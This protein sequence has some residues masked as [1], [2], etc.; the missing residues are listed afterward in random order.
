MHPC[1]VQHTWLPLLID[2]QSIYFVSETNAIF[3]T[4]NCNFRFVLPFEL[5]S[6][7]HSLWRFVNAYP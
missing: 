2:F 1:S 4:R 5:I 6:V 3:S 7:F